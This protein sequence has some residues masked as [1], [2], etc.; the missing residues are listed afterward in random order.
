MKKDI[1]EIKSFSLVVDNTQNKYFLFSLD[2]KGDS[3]TNIL[4]N[5]K[6]YKYRT[7]RSYM[8]SHNNNHQQQNRK[9]SKSRDRDSYRD[10]DYHH[11]RD[12][13]TYTYKDRDKEKSNN[14]DKEREFHSRGRDY[15]RESNYRDNNK[16]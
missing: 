9:N 16:E 6:K 4:N 10:K 1:D 13:D 12:R 8:D 14:R 11:S 3:F 2:F 5:F 15:I 7:N